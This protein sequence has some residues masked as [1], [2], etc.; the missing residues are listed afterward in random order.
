MGSRLSFAVSDVLIC[1]LVVSICFFE[2]NLFE[3]I[4]MIKNN[5]L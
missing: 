2:K 4:K 1:G 5:L 3:I